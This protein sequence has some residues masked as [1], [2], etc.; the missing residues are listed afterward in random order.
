[1][2]ESL[3]SVQK[4]DVPLQQAT[5]SS[6]EALKA[7]SLG[8]KALYE[9]SAAAALPYHQRAIELDANFAMGYNAV[10][11]DYYNLGEFVRSREYFAKAFQL[12]EHASE[13]ER[14]AIT[15]TYYWL[16]TGELDKASRTFQEEIA[17]YSPEFGECLELGQVFAAQGQYEKAAEM[18]RQALRLAPNNVN[19]YEGYLVPLRSWLTTLRR[20]EADHL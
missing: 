16:V 14:L 10:G 13:R 19:V 20:G 7:Y 18:G 15:G 4:F 2:G 17:S 8:N 1:L 11:I 3:A 9:E 5:T 12:R 6:L